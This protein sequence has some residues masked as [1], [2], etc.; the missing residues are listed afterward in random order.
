MAE[1]KEFPDICDVQIITM[2]CI[3]YRSVYVGWKRKA[4]GNKNVLVCIY[5]KRGRTHRLL[6]VKVLFKVV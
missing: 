1:V 4:S 2:I 3:D 5:L 6:L